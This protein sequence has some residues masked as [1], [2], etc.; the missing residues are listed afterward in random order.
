MPT[1]QW[2]PDATEPAHW[3]NFF[4]VTCAHHPKIC[5]RP[6]TLQELQRL[7]RLVGFC[8]ILN[9]SSNNGK[10]ALCP[11]GSFRMLRML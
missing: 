7:G 8:Y 9:L 3:P 4:S 11:Q 10:C 2:D 5:D 1:E 6:V